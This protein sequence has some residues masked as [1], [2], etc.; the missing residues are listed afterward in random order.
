MAHVCAK[1]HKKVL[2]EKTY[3]DSTSQSFQNPPI[4]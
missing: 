3:S 1:S 2:T 4:A